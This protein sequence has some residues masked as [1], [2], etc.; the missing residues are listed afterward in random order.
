MI[1]EGTVEQAT[2]EL[3]AELGYATSSGPATG[4][5]EPGAERYGFSEVVLRDRLREAI[6]R[7]NTSLPEDA[8]DEALRKVL[9]VGGLSLSRTNRAFHKMLRDGVPVEYTRPDGSIAGDLARIADLQNPDGND[10]LVVNQFTVLEGHHNRR[11]DVVVFLNGLPLGLIELKKPTDENA[12]I[13][14]AYQQLQT[15]KSEI[16]SI[17]QYNEVLV[18]SDGLQARIGSLTANQE[19][20]KVWRTV[21]GVE[22]AAPT[23]L[24]LDVL[25]RGVFEKRRFL[26]LLQ[27]YIVF[28]EDTESDRLGKIIAGYHQFH[29][30]TP[31]WFK[32]F[33]RAV[34]ERD[35]MEQRGR[36]GPAGRC[37]LA[38]ARVRQELLYAFLRCSNHTRASNGEP[39]AGSSH[40]P[41]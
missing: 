13:W 7:L 18:A 6:A 16:P 20:F 32:R 1:S 21:D 30:V 31:L 27:H 34:L 26:D 3:F 36:L 41:E 37:C 2:L 14:S 39:D 40:G 25:I 8:R 28:E 33:V 29:A 22:H 38:H 35:L 23:V 5:G 19:W 17:L 9:L 4:P 10:W 24:E 11:P 15:Y 12:S